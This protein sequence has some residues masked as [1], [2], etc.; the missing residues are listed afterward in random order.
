MS[1]PSV[2]ALKNINSVLDMTACCCFALAM[3]QK[4]FGDIFI[5]SI[6]TKSAMIE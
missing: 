1:N 4:H 6:P 3:S 2:K 5:A